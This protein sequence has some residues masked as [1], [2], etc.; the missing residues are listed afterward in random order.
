MW[1]QYKRVSHI[2]GFAVREI[3]K[4]T[5]MHYHLLGQNK[6]ILVIMHSYQGCICTNKF[7]KQG[8]TD[9]IHAGIE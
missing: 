8:D 9:A 6:V 3:I 4:T 5:A 2:S 7:I 1:C